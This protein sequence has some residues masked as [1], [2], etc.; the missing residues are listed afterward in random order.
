MSSYWVN[1]AA[2]GDPNGRGLPHWPAYE[3]KTDTAIEFGNTIELHP[4]LNKPAL[5][6][7]DKYFE[8]K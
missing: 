4:G 1:F 3:E 2:T 5:D 7:L 6:F 8:R